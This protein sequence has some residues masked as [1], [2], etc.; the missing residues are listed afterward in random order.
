[1]SIFSSLRGADCKVSRVRGSCRKSVEDRSLHGETRSFFF[2]WRLLRR[3]DGDEENGGHGS[4]LR[5]Q[6]FHG[7]SAICT[8][9]AD[10]DVTLYAGREVGITSARAAVVDDDVARQVEKDRMRIPE[11]FLRFLAV[12]VVSVENIEIRASEGIGSTLRGYGERSPYKLILQRVSFLNAAV[13][14]HEVKLGR[15]GHEPVDVAD[16]H[17]GG[18]GVGIVYYLHIDAA[19]TT[20]LSLEGEYDVA[21]PPTEGA[22]K[23]PSEFCGYVE[24]AAHDAKVGGGVWDVCR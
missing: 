12:K 21:L 20:S 17:L 11:E 9:C 1:M 13:Y 22:A 14:E 24:E 16:E 8:V 15:E 3:R 4:G 7:L 5:R 2:W 19:S 6:V 23:P 10:R 18:V